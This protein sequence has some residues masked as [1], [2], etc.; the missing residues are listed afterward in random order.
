MKKLLPLLLLILAFSTQAFATTFVVNNNGD[1]ND[2]NT[3]DNICADSLGNCTLRAA[4][5]QA[6][7][8]VSAD[9]ITFALPAPTTI[10]LTPLGPLTI[11]QSLTITGLGARNLIVQL[12]PNPPFLFRIFNIQGPANA[13][14]VNISGIT[15]ANGSDVNGGGGGGISNN[16]RNTLNLSEVT[17]RDNTTVSSGAG[18][19]NLGMLNIL[20]STISN[21]MSIG[22]NSAGG[23][24]TN[25]SLGQLDVGIV[26]I[27]NTTISNNSAV[28]GGG[29]IL[30]LSQMSLNNVT[31]SNNTATDSGGIFSLQTTSAK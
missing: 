29:G 28:G 31:I 14:T 18:I 4:I 12:Q 27:A 7:A 25:Y 10:N 19:L 3:T 9:T 13:T 26:N 17:I 16:G 15:I 24:I 5:Q 1:T 6:N 30:N 2:A 21:N 23:G 11:I 20:N 22:T 8:T